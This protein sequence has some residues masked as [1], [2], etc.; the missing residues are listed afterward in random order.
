VAA[1]RATFRQVTVTAPAGCGWTIA[2]NEPWVHY[3]PGG[4]N[5]TATVLVSVDPNPLAAS[6]LAKLT[7]TVAG[8]PTPSSAADIVQSAPPPPI[9]ACQKVRLGREAEQVG[10][11]I[12][13]GS[14]GLFADT[15]AWQITATQDWI[16]LTGGTGGV[17]TTDIEYQLQAN[18]V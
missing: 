7:A 10:P 5:G 1:A 11:N 14:V 16:T 18:T 4:G 13:Q 9:P 3:G 2:A 8:S 17:G 12:I 6:R 15:C